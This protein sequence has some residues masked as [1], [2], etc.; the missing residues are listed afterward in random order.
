MSMTPRYRKSLN[1]FAPAGG[2]NGVDVDVSCDHRI[3]PGNR[4]LPEDV[5]GITFHDYSINV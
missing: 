3:C 2:L 1:S 4:W 5:V